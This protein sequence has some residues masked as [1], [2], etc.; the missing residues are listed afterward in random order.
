M[1]KVVIFIAGCL[2]AGVLIHLA[3]GIS[4]VLGLRGTA[5]IRRSVD[6]HLTDR[7]KNGAKNA[8][9]ALAPAELKKNTPKR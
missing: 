5:V 3:I 7:A 6:D 4:A 8:G 9:P 1:D 2:A